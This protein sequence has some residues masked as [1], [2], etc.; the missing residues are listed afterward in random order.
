[1]RDY[2]QLYLIKTAPVVAGQKPPSV[3]FMWD[4]SDNKGSVKREVKNESRIHER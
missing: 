1:M 2:R 3:L 4:W